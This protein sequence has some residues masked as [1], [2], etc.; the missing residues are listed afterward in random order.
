MDMIVNQPGSPTHLAVLKSLTNFKGLNGLTVF[1]T[2]YVIPKSLKFSQTILK[3]RRNPTSPR[4]N[5]CQFLGAR[6]SHVTVGSYGGPQ[7]WMFLINLEAQIIPRLFGSGLTWLT[8]EFQHIWVLLTYQKKLP[9]RETHASFSFSLLVG[10]VSSPEGIQLPGS[11]SWPLF[12]LKPML[13]G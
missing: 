12:S 5:T 6:F 2:K 1:P 9:S 10:Y 3:N 8:F 13:G 11:L 7:T 4:F